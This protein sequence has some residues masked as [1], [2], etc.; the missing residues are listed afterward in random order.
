MAPH[1]AKAKAGHSLQVVQNTKPARIQTPG[2]LNTV[3]A[4]TSGN[5]DQ[6]GTFM[7]HPN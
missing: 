5:P 3:L 2:Q 4:L 7:K 6:E 1:R